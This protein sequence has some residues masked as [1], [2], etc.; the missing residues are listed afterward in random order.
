MKQGKIY[1][2]DFFNET[3]RNTINYDT[4]SLIVFIHK[5]GFIAM[6]RRVTN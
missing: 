2:L 4:S 6:I 1:V 5:R 3:G